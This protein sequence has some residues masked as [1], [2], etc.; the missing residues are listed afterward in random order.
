MK[1]LGWGVESGTDYW[2]VANSWNSDWGDKGKNTGSKVCTTQR[3]KKNI[4]ADFQNSNL[5][6]GPLVCIC[7][8]RTTCI[9]DY[10]CN[11]MYYVVHVV[12]VPLVLLFTAL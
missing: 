7:V 5:T 11:Q 9:N 3:T 12:I 4:P 6:I 2:L 10:R 1:I 8:I